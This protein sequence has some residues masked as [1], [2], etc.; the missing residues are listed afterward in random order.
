MSSAHGAHGLGLATTAS[1][2]SPRIELPNPP[3]TDAPAAIVLRPWSTT[4]S[5][6]LALMAAWGD[7]VLAAADGVPDDASAVSALRWIRGDARRRA[8]GRCLDMVVSPLD[9][10]GTVLGEVG[11]RNIDRRRRRAE[12]SWWTAPAHRGRRLARAATRLLAGWA[13]A[14]DGMDLVQV[15]ARIDPGNTASRRVADAAGLSQLGVADGTQVWARTRA[16]APGE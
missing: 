13:L 3:L 1:V 5:D 15:W 10:D 11:L 8:A 2:A 9:G 16:A 14:P 4:E 7:P 6:V 12:L